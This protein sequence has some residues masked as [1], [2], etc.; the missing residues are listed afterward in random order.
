MTFQLI[1]SLKRIVFAS[2]LFE[3]S[4]WAIVGSI[5]S[6]ALGL[7]SAIIVARLLGKSIYGE[8]GMIRNTVL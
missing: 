8:Y 4:F 2:K 3:D 7:G 1:S 6:R 5:T